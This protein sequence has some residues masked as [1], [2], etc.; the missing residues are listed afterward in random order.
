MRQLGTIGEYLSECGVTQ[1]LAIFEFE[2]VQLAAAF[3][4]LDQTRITQVKAIYIRETKKLQTKSKQFML[5]LF[6]C[7][8]SSSILFRSQTHFEVLK[9]RTVYGESGERE[10]FS[11][12]RMVEGPA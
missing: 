3:G 1:A 7:S 10:A 6:C 8:K 11:N 9:I 12:Y 4:H 2:R 5:F